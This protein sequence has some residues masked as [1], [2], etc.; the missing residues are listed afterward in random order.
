MGDA[1]L[2]F[3]SDTRLW[4]AVVQRLISD[5]WRSGRLLQLLCRTVL[6]RFQTGSKLQALHH[7]RRGS[8]GTWSGFKIDPGQGLPALLP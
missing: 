1:F 5:Q 6:E 4:L 8:A 3:G 2:P 7:K